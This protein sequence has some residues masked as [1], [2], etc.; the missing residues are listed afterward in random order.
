M[1]AL[2]KAAVINCAKSSGIPV[3]RMRVDTKKWN[4]GGVARDSPPM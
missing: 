1:N 3:N 2:K 4:P